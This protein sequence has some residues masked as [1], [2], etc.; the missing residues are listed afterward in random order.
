MAPWVETFGHVE[1][2]APLVYEDAYGRLCL[3]ANQASVAA[4]L[5]LR[6]GLRVTVR[7]A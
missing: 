6:E 7:R 2:G 1:R 3:A 5:G 4:L